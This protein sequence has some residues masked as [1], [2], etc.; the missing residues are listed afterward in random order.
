MRVR[1]VLLARFAV[2]C[3]LSI[4][5]AF[6]LP[7]A[8]DELDVSH[9]GYARE[10]QPSKTADP[11]S[12]VVIEAEEGT[13]EQVDGETVIVVQ[14]PAPIAASAEAP[15]PPEIIVVEEQI[16]PCPGGVWVDGYWYYSNGQYLWV[17]G[18]CVV[19]RVNYVFVHPRWDFYTGIWWFVPGYY[20]PCAAY[21]GFGYYRPWYWYP[22]YYHPYYP[23]RRP[24]PV[25]R[26]VPRRPTSAHP[27]PARRTPSRGISGRP[28]ATPRRITRAP[29]QPTTV[30]YRTPTGAT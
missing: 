4:A 18:H 5:T 23:A 7:A 20:R 15:P 24:V 26:G 17:D 1:V 29:T 10:G 13:T 6:A 8:A 3:A 28:D 9:D 21:V 19:V 11:T 16:P 27:T 2:L 30:I 22:P 25:Y 14:E 12:Y